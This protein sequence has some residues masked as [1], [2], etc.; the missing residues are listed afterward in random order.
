M[1]AVSTVTNYLIKMIAAQCISGSFKVCMNAYGRRKILPINA[2]KLS[3]F[4]CWI[5]LSSKWEKGNPRM[6]NSTKALGQ[7]ASAI[8]LRN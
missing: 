7:E 1:L 6:Y 8:R 5:I 3:V 2:S 4:Y